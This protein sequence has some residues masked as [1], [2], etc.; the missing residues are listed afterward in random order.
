MTQQLKRALLSVRGLH[1]SYGGVMALDGLDLELVAGEAVA[2]VGHNGSGKT[3]ALWIISGRLD[4]SKGRVEI[5]GTDVHVRRNAAAVRSRIAFVPDSPALYED[6]TVLDHLELVGLAHGVD[7]LDRRIDVVLE[8]LGLSE[9]RRL[10][11]RELSRGMRQKTQ[12]ACALVRP[13]EVLLL[14][15]PVVGLDPPSQETLH[16]MLGEAKRQGAAVLFSTHQLAFARNLADRGVVLSDG[17][18]VASG[19][20]ADVVDASDVRRLK[21]E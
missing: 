13:F 2:L 10:L 4:P 1:R 8:R 6:L 12:I 9:R 3:T 16:A 17:K 7:D 21:F 14:D 15:E 18:V 19:A 20:Y 5:G 11:P